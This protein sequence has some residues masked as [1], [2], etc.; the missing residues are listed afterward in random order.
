MTERTKQ[1]EPQDGGVVEAY[2]RGDTAKAQALADAAMDRMRDEEGGKGGD[3]AS[4]APSRDDDWLLGDD[5]GGDDAVADEGWDKEIAD[6]QDHL[7]HDPEG[8][9]L[10]RSWASDFQQNT[11]IA[12]ELGRYFVSAAPELRDVQMSPALLEVL[13]EIG[14]AMLGDQKLGELRGEAGEATMG[15]RPG[16]TQAAREEID[17]LLAEHFGKPSYNKPVVQRRLAELHRM[18]GSNAPIGFGAG[19]EQAQAGYGSGS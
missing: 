16:R 17:E 6:F 8:F 4:E 3:K 14:A 12:V 10:V 13:Y 1:A 11:E 15:Y 7:R 19:P 5:A 2:A 18:L 9:A